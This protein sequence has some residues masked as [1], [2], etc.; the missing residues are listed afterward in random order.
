MQKEN[1]GQVQP[2]VEIRV[3]IPEG[4]NRGSSTH[5]L[6]CR[7]TTNDKRGRFPSPR[8]TGKLGNDGIF[9]NNKAFTLIELLVVV[10]IIGILAAVALPQYEKAVWKSR[11][12]T[13]QTFLRNVENAQQAYYLANATQATE[14]DELAVSFEGFTAGSVLGGSSSAPIKAYNDMFEIRLEASNSIAYFISGKYKGCGFRV[15]KMGEWACKEWNAYYK[16]AGGFCQKIMKAG[17]LV[18]EENNMREYAM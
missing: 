1:V 10:L 17:E 9:Y 16:T 15:N 8:R 2:D 12:A 11:A 7:K 5:P 13:M 18:R 4:C 3:V 6:F 14:L